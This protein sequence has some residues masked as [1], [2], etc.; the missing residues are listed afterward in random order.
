LLVTVAN[1]VSPV[2]P[3]AELTELIAR[4]IEGDEAARNRFIDLIYARL[5]R[6]VARIYSS[7]PS[8]RRRTSVT[9]VTHNALLRMIREFERIR[10]DRTP[11][12]VRDFFTLMMQ[13]VRH[14]LVDEY[15]RMNRKTEARERFLLD[16]D[17]AT[18]E[19]QDHARVRGR[20]PSQEVEEEEFRRFALGVLGEALPQLEPLEQQIVEMKFTLGLSNKTI[21]I[22]LGESEK[23]ISRKWLTAKLKLGRL[24]PGQLGDYFDD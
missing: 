7:Y 21:S 6:L 5:V 11:R 15:R 17:S 18:G 20:D 24:L 3:D 2:D 4:W 12:T 23:Q 19:R 8:V 16:D 10:A 14:C 9:S 1:E 22:A 13:I